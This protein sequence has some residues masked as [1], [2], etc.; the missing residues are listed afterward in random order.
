[1]ARIL[2]VQHWDNAFEYNNA[3]FFARRADVVDKALI[4]AGQAAPDPR[5]YDLVTIYGGNM[6]AYDEKAN[7][8]IPRELDFVEACLKAGTP[9]LGICLGSQLLA[10]A[11][12]SRAYRSP[13]P[14]FGFKRVRLNARG[15]ADPILG[16][17]GD[18]SAAFLA[19]EWHDDAWD[20]PAGASLLA[21]SE[22]WPN[23]AFRYGPNALGIQFH[24]E[25]T[26]AHM[27]WAV[28]RPGEA[29]SQDPEAEDPEA[30]ASPGPRYEELKGNMEKILGSLL[31]AE[32]LAPA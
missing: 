3:P 17:L 19:I 7:P 1:M 13:A 21:S 9:L 4:F 14:E 20:L 26:Q 2:N 29:R 28:A 11:L 10:R 8:W 27:A 6:S 18:E 30:F 16:A 25:F 22:A 5:D 31:Q 24:L 32:S 15:V 12:G 23:Q